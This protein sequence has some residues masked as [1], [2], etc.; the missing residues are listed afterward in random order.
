MLGEPTE[1]D[2]LATELGTLE[3][4]RQNF[5][6]AVRWLQ[7]AVDRNPHHREARYQ[8]AK[9]LQSLGKADQAQPHFDFLASLEPRLREIDALSDQI[10]KHGDDLEARFRMGVLQLEVGS[11]ETGL[12][13]LRSVVARDPKH[14][15]ARAL[16]DKHTAEP[17]L[18][19]KNLNEP[20]A[21]QQRRSP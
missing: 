8:L 12:Y 9:T 13:W 1:D 14:S 7:R 18:G 20:Q 3:A 10:N 17:L 11:K 5:A 16:I 2:A 19:D 21:Q 6:E 15:Q 4:N